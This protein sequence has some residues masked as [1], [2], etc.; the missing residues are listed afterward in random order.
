[1]RAR[2][3]L[4]VLACF[5]AFYHPTK[6]RFR[7]SAQFWV[8]SVRVQRLFLTI[9]TTPAPH[10]GMI[11][12]MVDTFCSS[13]AGSMTVDGQLTL[14]RPSPVDG[15]VSPICYAPGHRSA[16]LPTFPT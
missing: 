9:V 1:M 2:H 7:R 8:T 5:V 14:M 15:S 11:R 13:P 6:R 12:F 16:Q 3:R 4:F 10:K